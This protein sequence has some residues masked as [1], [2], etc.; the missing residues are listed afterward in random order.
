M[1][2]ILVAIFS[3]SYRRQNRT[4]LSRVIIH[5][6]HVVTQLTQQIEHQFD[7]M[8]ADIRILSQLNEFKA[9]VTTGDSRTLNK[10]GR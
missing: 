5:E 4:F 10:I 7:M 1:M 2:A 6:N 3:Q 9:Y 8:Y